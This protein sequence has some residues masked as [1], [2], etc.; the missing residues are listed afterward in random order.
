M[1]KFEYKV[2]SG[3]PTKQELEAELKEAGD[4][5]WELIKV[6]HFMGNIH[7]YFRREKEEEAY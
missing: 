6:V 3:T 2:N 1:K 7:H 4:Q 5:G